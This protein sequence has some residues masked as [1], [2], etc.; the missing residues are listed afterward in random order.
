MTAALEVHPGGSVMANLINLIVSSRDYIQVVGL[1]SGGC[2]I[3][4]TV[5]SL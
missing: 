2:L 4:L 5:M 1:R 3:V